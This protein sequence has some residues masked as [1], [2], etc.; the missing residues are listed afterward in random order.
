MR[1]LV[2]EDNPKIAQAIKDVLTTEAFA[3]D[4]AHS[5]D[6]GL[7]SALYEPYDLLIL[8]RMLSQGADG[9]E[10]CQTLRTEGKHMP[11]IMV[12]AKDQVNQRIEGLNAG[13]DDY[14][15]KPFSFEE[16]IAR[17]RALLRRPDDSLGTVL[18]TGDLALDTVRMRVE[19][20][21]VEIKLSRT[22]YALLEYLLRHSGQT[23]SKQH[24]IA[25]VWDFAADILPNTVEAYITRLRNKIDKPFN[26]PELI[27]TVHGFGYCLDKRT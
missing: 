16:L 11:I 7:Q 6:E 5:G 17:V 1:L 22:E 23:L 21:G 4:V 26:S 15:I 10:I 24:L 13:A 12:T 25:H 27:R 9:V 19:R 18:H 3:V 2:I 8:D 14:L 20:A